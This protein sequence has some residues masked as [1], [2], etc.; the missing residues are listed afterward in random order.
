[1]R[2]LIKLFPLITNEPNDFLR[3]LSFRSARY[4]IRYNNNVGIAT[5][6]QNSSFAQSHRVALHLGM[7][8]ER[9]EGRD[10]PTEVLTSARLSL[11][12]F[13]L[14]AITRHNRTR[15]SEGTAALD[16]VANS[17]RGGL[18]F[19]CTLAHEYTCAGHRAEA[20]CIMYE[21]RE[22]P[23]FQAAQPFSFCDID[24]VVSQ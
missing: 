13:T 2:W 21:R 10:L 11:L 4:A 24:L 22:S 5:S 7:R 12:F 9:N 6:L 23:S 17:A 20:A 8:S 14:Q 19:F 18:V 1:M 15:N 16:T 3:K